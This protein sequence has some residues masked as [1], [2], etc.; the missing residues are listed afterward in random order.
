MKALRFGFMIMLASCTLYSAR[1]RAQYSY[2]GPED[3]ARCRAQAAATGAAAGGLLGYGLGCEEEFRVSSH[4]FEFANDRYHKYRY[5]M[6][7]EAQNVRIVQLLSG[8]DG[9]V[10]P[11]FCRLYHVEYLSPDVRQ[12]RAF[13]TTM[14]L[15]NGGWVFPNTAP[16]V[17]VIVRQYQAVQNPMINV[18]VSPVY[19]PEPARPA[20]GPY[21]YAPSPALQNFEQRAQ[22][23][24]A[25]EPPPDFAPPEDRPA[26]PG[27][28]PR[29][30]Q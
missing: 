21:R 15:V 9:A 28:Y 27:F 10:P 1:A 3:F 6:P 20:V 18:Q 4:L 8:Y 12:W 2:H 5:Y 19:R 25:M 14:C 29:R 30:V 17:P 23:P 24:R 16:G 13:Q 22:A 26:S 7:Y 11:H